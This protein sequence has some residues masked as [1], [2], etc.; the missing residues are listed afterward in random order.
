MCETINS[1][2]NGITHVIFDLDGTLIDTELWSL[3]NVNTL[4]SP[5]GKVCTASTYSTVLGLDPLERSKRIIEEFELDYDKESFVTISG[6][7]N[8]KIKVLDNKIEYLP[9]ADFTGKEVLTCKYKKNK[10][11]FILIV[12]INVG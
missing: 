7:D 4:L 10:I 3:N 8:G 9:N 1:N 12:T 6:S 2:I 5:Y 11:D